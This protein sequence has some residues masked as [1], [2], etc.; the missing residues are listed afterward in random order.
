MFSY[1][2]KLVSHSRALRKN[3]TPEEK[4]LWYQCLKRLPLTVHRQK[5]IGN[6]IVDFY[7]AAKKTV[8]EIDGGQH[9]ETANQE[10][11]QQRDK[12][13]ASLG[14]TVLRY[15]NDDIRTRFEGV[16]QDIFQRLDISFEMLK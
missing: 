6:Y 1:N 13:L 11:D 12:A 15:N 2:K 10:K 14:I 16:V 5:M 4:K 3:M 9:F 8:I 7:V